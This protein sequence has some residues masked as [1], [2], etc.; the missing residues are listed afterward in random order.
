MTSIDVGYFG[1]THRRRMG[2]LHHPSADAPRRT[3]G[4]V[5]CPPL[6]YDALCAHRSVRHLAVAAAAAGYAVLRF[7]YDGTGDSVGSAEDAARWSAWQASIGDAVHA[8]REFA[9]V[10]RIVLLGI[11]LGATLAATV[12]ADADSDVA[13]VAAIAAIV[14][15]KSW[16]REL[17]AL[18]RVMGRAEAPAGLEIPEGSE[19]FVGILITAESREAIERMDLTSLSFSPLVQWLVLDR[20]DRAPSA[21]WLTALEQQGAP[22]EHAL[23]PGY[24]EMM[25]DP[26]AS[27]VP[28]E[29]IAR[30]VQWL[31]AKFSEAASNV[32]PVLA[33]SVEPAL[34][35]TSVREVPL[36]FGASEALFGVVTRPVEVTPTR[37]LILLNSGANLH[38]GN[39]RM[40]VEYAR[41]LAAKGWLVLRYDVSGIGESAPHPGRPENEVY[42]PKGVDDLREAVAY[43][44][45][46]L[47]VSHVQA[48]GLC[49]GAYNAFRGADA[50]VPLDGIVVINPL[51]FR[52]HEG[53]SLKYPAY[54]MAMTAERYRKSIRDWSKWVKFLRG[55]VDL[56]H[57]TAVVVDRVRERGRLLVRDARRALGVP[58]ADDLGTKLLG[59]IQRGVR[60]RFF[61]SEGDP[62]E[63]LLRTGAGRA[64]TQLLSSGQ[65]KVATL[66]GCDHS[67]SAAWMR[68]LLWRE[69]DR[70]LAE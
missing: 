27:Q 60:V 13:G 8:F 15:G 28:R 29:M 44:R 24:V 66:P 22:V 53:M 6:G 70:S 9:A 38:I 30:F 25:Q 59:L 56:P 48:A 69:L 39:G 41:R 3:T 37:A 23:L 50:G 1:P 32:A 2:W 33:L 58:V 57:A 31:E 54:V 45:E 65:I 64:F 42:S 62:G 21:A 20:S 51:T 49:S 40:Y 35:S 67:I 34:V 52:W 55:G 43:V 16:L 61:F 68:E 47:G 10:E 4:I 36:R 46:T 26:H 18:K 12:A 5:I 14:S 7:D 17:R 19:E 11:G 63:S